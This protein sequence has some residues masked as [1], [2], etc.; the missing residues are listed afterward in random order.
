MY[1]IYMVD[2]AMYTIYM[3]DKAMYTI[4]MVDAG[5]VYHLHGRYNPYIYISLTW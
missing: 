5:Y 1:T 3:V 4:Y 2:K